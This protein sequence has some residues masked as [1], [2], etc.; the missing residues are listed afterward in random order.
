MSTTSF[1]RMEPFL[2]DVRKHCF[3]LAKHEWDAEDLLQD[4]LTKA[5]RSIQQQPE[6]ELSKAYLKQIATNAWIDHCRKKQ[7]NRRGEVFDEALHLQKSVPDDPFTIRENFE[8]LANRLNARQM[9]L[10]LLIDI[11]SFT[12]PETARLLNM[13][14]GAV[15]EGV[16][17]ARHRLQ[18]LASQARGDRDDS[19]GDL[20]KRQAAAALVTKED[21]EQFLAAFRAGDPY[22][23]CDTYLQFA[24]HGVRIE[25]VSV[26]A[27]KLFF[28][29]RDPDGHLITFFQEWP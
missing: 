16:K 21:F 9:V 11:F 18:S 28:S 7:T 1:S 6:R 8:Q 26:R 19:D 25:K 17:R 10:I 5:Y 20:R 22:A 4:T 13:T 14:V 23:L 3:L 24:E 15:K 27:D 29:V 12:A 2:A